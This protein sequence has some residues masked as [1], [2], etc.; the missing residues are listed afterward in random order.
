MSPVKNELAGRLAE[1][2]AAWTA[3]I[4]TLAEE[5]RALIRGDAEA[6]AA[7]NAVKL[8][9][10]HAA[11][12]FAR[13]RAESLRAAGFSPDA[14]GMA[15][16][17]A[18]HGSAAARTDWSRLQ[19]LEDEARASNARVGKL[20]EMRLSANRQALNVLMHAAAGQNGLY[21]PSGQAIAARGGA[22]LAAA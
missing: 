4:D 13:E 1:E 20:I 8:E 17:L 22:P 15:A 16:W 5:A 21:D 12:G 19:A 10:L 7:L 14:A 9:R 2:N 3:L 6:L 11:G 18:A